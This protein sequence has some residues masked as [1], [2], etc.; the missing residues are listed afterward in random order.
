ML[1]GLWVVFFLLGLQGLCRDGSDAV[2]VGK[3][4]G[5]GVQHGVEGSL[6]RGRQS[7]SG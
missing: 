6:F 1:H 3:E 4:A 2:V 5:V 7:G